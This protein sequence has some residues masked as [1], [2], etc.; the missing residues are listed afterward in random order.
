MSFR[1]QERE[2]KEITEAVDKYKLLTERLDTIFLEFQNELKNTSVNCEKWEANI[3]EVRNI[4]SELEIN[5]KRIICPRNN[6]CDWNVGDWVG[7]DRQYPVDE[8][9][10]NARDN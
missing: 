2:L 3:K 9:I 4:I 8:R 7:E 5:V 1:P 6:K 10:T